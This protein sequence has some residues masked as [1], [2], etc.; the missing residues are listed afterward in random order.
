MLAERHDTSVDGQ[1]RFYLLSAAENTGEPQPL[2]LDLHGLLEGAQIHSAMTGFGELA[3]RE[4]F[5]AAFPHGSG[6]PVKWQAELDADPNLDLEYLDALLA[7]V[8]Q[9]RCV[10]EARVYVTGLSYGAIMSSTLGCLRPDVFAAMAPVNGIS[11]PEGCDPVRPIPIW[12]T[13]GTVDPI[14]LFNGGFGDVAGM[15]NGEIPVDLTIP[16]GTPETDVNG[17]GYPATVAAWAQRNGCGS[18]TDTDVTAT[19]IKRVYDCPNG[20]EVEFVIAVDSGH[21][22]PGSAFSASIAKVVGPTTMD[23]NASEEAWKFFQR[24]SLPQAS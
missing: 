19:V 11:D 3:Q 4:G 12:T 13:H 1:E 9:Q 6:D 7:Q 8:G 10:D 20:A 23:L 5:I 17:P 2:V 14:L 15:L 16:P 24:F 22:W 21:G 18:F